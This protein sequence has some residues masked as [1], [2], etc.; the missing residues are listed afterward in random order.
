M[1]TL[2][3][4]DLAQPLSSLVP[5]VDGDV[6]TVLARTEAPLTG[7]RVAA[8]ARRG[9]RPAVQAV[10]DR[11][12]AHGV[13]HAQPAGSAVLYT[14][15]RDH[16]LADPVVAAVTAR[17]RLLALLRERIEAWPLQALHT[18]MFGSTARGEAGPTSD[19]DVLVIRADDVDADD[20]AWAGQLAE[21][22]Q[23]VASWTGNELSWFETN[24]DGLRRA[25][26][27]GEPLIDSLSR[28]GIHLTGARWS[29]TLAEVGTP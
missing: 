7:R 14:L 16:L 21:L 5:S 13:V 12:V 17:D 6:L 3:D 15:N 28:D 11:L 20:P 4:M 29:R 8:L 27:E 9:S 19:L 18:S 1:G 26:A 24:R 23:L 10:L 22:E 25:A 2:V